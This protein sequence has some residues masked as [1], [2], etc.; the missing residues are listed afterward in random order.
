MPSTTLSPEHRAA[1]DRLSLTPGRCPD[2]H[3]ELVCVNIDPW[4]GKDVGKIPPPR[5]A[6]PFHDVW[7]TECFDAG[8]PKDPTYKGG[9]WHA[10]LRDVADPAWH[11]LPEAMRAPAMRWGFTLHYPGPFLPYPRFRVGVC[12]GK[13]WVGDRG[14][15]L[16]VGP[17][18]E[19]DAVIARA[20]FQVSPASALPR[21]Q[22]KHRVSEAQLAPLVR[23]PGDG[24]VYEETSVVAEKSV[25]MHVRVGDVRIPTWVV[26]LVG[27]LYGD[28]RWLARGDKERVVAVRGDE[29]V[30][31][32]MPLKEHKDEPASAAE[33]RAS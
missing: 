27:E 3:E 19:A 28:V 10:V 5:F 25:E 6:C 12:D 15:L 8:D 14:T 13:T 31:V 4:D 30:A 9:C 22:A 32:A 20:D 16:L 29:V 33:V 11:F 26:S 2:C 1:I 24:Y 17:A 7:L 23:W 21:V 18:E